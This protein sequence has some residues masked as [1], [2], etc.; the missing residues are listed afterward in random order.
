[1]EDLI[2]KG[3]DT[4]NETNAVRLPNAIKRAKNM[5]LSTDPNAPTQ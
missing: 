3:E 4:V 2:A 5:T 1:M